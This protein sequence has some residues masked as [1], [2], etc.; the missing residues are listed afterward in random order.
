MKIDRY[1]LPSAFI[2]GSIL[3]VAG[4]KTTDQ[5]SEARKSQDAAMQDPYSYGPDAKS[6]QNRGRDDD[7]DPTDISGGGTSE[8]NK[9]ALK[10]DWDAVWGN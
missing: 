10:R 3:L 2:C 4:C 5:P 7:V 1:L 8:L 9:K 6:M